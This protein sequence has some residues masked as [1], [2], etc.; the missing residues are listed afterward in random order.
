MQSEIQGHMPIGMLASLVVTVAYRPEYSTDKVY[1][2]DIPMPVTIVV[3]EMYVDKFVE[4]ARFNLGL[5]EYVDFAAEELDTLD[6]FIET[7]KGYCPYIV[8]SMFVDF[9]GKVLV[10]EDLEAT[11]NFPSSS[12]MR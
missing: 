1:A 5:E 12:S 8:N 7:Y 9:M 6:K 11:C 2:D 10:I 3:P 4:E